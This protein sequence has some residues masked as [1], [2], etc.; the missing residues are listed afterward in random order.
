MSHL[1]THFVSCFQLRPGEVRQRSAPNHRF[2]HRS[3]CL[4]RHRS[5]ALGAL[6]PDLP[7]DRFP[8]PRTGPI[9]SAVTSRDA[10]SSAS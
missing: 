7:S 10:R 2:L 3:A 6:V 1:T 9:S 8:K 5:H 4:G